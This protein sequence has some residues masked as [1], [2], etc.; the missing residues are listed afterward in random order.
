MDTEPPTSMATA[1]LLSL[2]ETSG[3]MEAAAAMACV[4]GA[5]VQCKRAPCI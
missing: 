4:S 5:S 3:A 1:A 2:F